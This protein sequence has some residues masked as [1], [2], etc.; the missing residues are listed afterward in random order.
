M[1]NTTGK[2]TKD[3]QLLTA[4][5]NGTATTHHVHIHEA[6]Q[7]H[8]EQAVAGQNHDNLCNKCSTDS[9]RQNESRTAADGK[10]QPG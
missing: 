9:S 7:Q 10:A 6:T 2:T 1:G 4:C 8:H 5:V 3:M